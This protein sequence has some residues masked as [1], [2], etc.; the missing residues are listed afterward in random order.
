MS[1]KVPCEGILIEQAL[2]ETGQNKTLKR[3]LSLWDLLAIGIGGLFGQE[4]LFTLDSSPGA[5]LYFLIAEIPCA[6]GVCRPLSKVLVDC[7]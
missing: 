4:F 6:E 3:H 5:P 1:R 7:S 2:E